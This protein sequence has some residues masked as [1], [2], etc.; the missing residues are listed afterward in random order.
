MR[1]QGEPNFQANLAG[2]FDRKKKNA[3]LVAQSR[4]GTIQAIALDCHGKIRPHC[5]LLNA[6]QS[7][8]MRQAA[9]VNSSADLATPF[10]PET[11]ATTGVD[12]AL[13]PRRAA[14]GQYRL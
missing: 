8:A 2:K 10:M 12:V 9:V 5:C 1:I 4:P 7:A 13:T 6:Y 11:P 3:V 14:A